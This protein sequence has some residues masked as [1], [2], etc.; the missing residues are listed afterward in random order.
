VAAG[1]AYLHGETIVHGDVKVS[2]VVIGADGR[3][4]LADFGCTRKVCVGTSRPIIGG[5]PA[6]MAPEVVRGEEQGPAADVW[7]LGCT[8]VEK[9][10][11]RAPWSG[12]DGDVLA[13]MHRIS[14]NGWRARAVRGR[15]RATEHVRAAAR[16]ARRRPQ[17]RG[18]LLEEGT[19]GE[20]GRRGAHL[21]AGVGERRA[22]ATEWRAWESCGR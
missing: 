16:R 10:I 11:G 4:K 2:N 15:Q 13:A 9:A 20:E 12:M 22:T 8:V 5:T 21:I 7:A 3:A 1:L 18:A 6:F 19:R 14:S 17:R